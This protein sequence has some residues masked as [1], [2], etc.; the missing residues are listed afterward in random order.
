MSSWGWAM[1]FH[2]MRQVPCSSAT[3]MASFEA[4][5][6]EKREGGIWGEEEEEERKRDR[7]AEEAVMKEEGRGKTCK[8]K[9]NMIVEM[10]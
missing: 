8:Q 9:E 5:G 10:E 2:L 6:R 3:E 1:L 7:T 4:G